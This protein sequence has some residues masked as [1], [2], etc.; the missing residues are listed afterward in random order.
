M[1]RPKRNPTAESCRWSLRLPGCTPGIA[2]VVLLLL[3]GMPSSSQADVLEEVKA[4]ARVRDYAKMVK[5]LKP[6][7]VKGDGEAQYQ[8]GRLYRSGRGV[9]E[10]NKAA[11]QWMQKAAEQGHVKAQY[12]LGVMYENGWGVDPSKKSLDNQYRS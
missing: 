10:D 4:A 6:L 11:F 2:V 12:N 9:S 7:A 1:G 8:L 3:M 5:L